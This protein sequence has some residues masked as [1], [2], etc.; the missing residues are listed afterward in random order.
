MSTFVL[1]HGGWHGAWCWS[2]VT[3]LLEQAGHCVIAPD[4][5][6]HGAD[7]TPLSARPHELYLPRVV[8]ILDRLDEPAI[9]L[10]HSSGGMLI[11]ELARQRPGRIKVLV[12]LSAFLLGPGKTP[13]D[14]MRDDTES[15]LI[16]SIVFDHEKGVSI[17]K[18]EH[19]REVFYADCTDEDAAWA[20]SRLQ[21][22]PLIPPNS[23]P[24]VV[25]TGEEAGAAQVPC[26]YVECLKDKA[27][28][29]ATQKRMYTDAGCRKVY[30][31]STS[32]SPFISAP[33]EL[34]ECLLDVARTFAA[35]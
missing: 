28:G 13:R 15:I 24:L 12:Y 26:V 7:K 2:R 8:E 21:P 20:I 35:I 22:E 33:K 32:H 31:L 10:G 17:V 19:A 6:G 16:S 23:D 18:P 5:P 25:E 34:A 3:P 11:S 30:S 14:A 27:L 9:V 1:I 29:P 4:L